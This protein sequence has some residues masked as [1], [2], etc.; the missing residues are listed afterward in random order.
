[1]SYRPTIGGKLREEPS[2]VDRS[3]AA[4]CFWGDGPR[5]GEHMT[6]ENNIAV[7]EAYLKGLRNKD[8]SNVSFA[9][10]VTF[11][12][13]RVPKLTGR[14]DVIAF[15]TSILPAIKDI[16]IKQHIAEGEYVATVF[17]METIFGT[18][19]VFDLLHV[20]D[21]QLKAIHSFYYPQ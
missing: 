10:E 12:G 6:R 15:L 21:G 17:D 9:A 14:E 1:M 3:Q 13:P 8:L 19:R 5:Q 7:V 4:S 11:E 2:G 18:N 16:H 20:S